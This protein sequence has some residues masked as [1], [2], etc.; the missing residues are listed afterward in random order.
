M[1][2]WGCPG[3]PEPVLSQ[4]L[5]ACSGDAPRGAS[6]R[7][8][9]PWALQSGTAALLQAHSCLSCYNDIS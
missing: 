2:L 4:G 9:Q 1:C 6:A 3:D 7:L 8:C 5:R